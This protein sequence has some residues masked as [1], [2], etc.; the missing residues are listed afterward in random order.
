MDLETTGTPA[1]RGRGQPIAGIKRQRS[2]SAR[3]RAARRMRYRQRALRQS[4]GAGHN[5][6]Q[7]PPLFESNSMFTQAPWHWAKPGQGEA[8][9]H[10]WYGSPRIRVNAR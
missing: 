8:A 5:T 10:L 4:A 3:A 7:P 9:D 6:S 1:A 2:G